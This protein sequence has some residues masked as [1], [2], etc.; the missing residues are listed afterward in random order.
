LGWAIAIAAGVLTSLAA[1]GQGHINPAVSIG[2]AIAG[3]ASWG[4]VPLLVA[5][6]FVGGAIGAVLV[7][8]AYLSHWEVTDDPAVKLGV[9]ATGPQI[10]RPGA[11]LLTEAI[12]T[13]VLVIGVLAFVEQVGL[14]GLVPLYVG[15]LV[16][17]IGMGLGGPTGFAINP[18][19]DLAPRAMHAVLPIPGKGGSDWSYA[20]IPVAGPIG[21]GVVAGLLGTLVF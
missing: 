19:R 6:Q 2:L 21:G 12:G 10:R 4:D 3:E 5:G 15:L 13:F 18:A 17:A 9:F 14:G 1:G 7:W 11:N 8:L 16:G 20:W